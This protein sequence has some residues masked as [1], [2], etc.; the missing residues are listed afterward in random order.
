MLSDPLQAPVTSLSLREQIYARLRAAMMQGRYEPEMTLKISELAETFGTSVVP[1]REALQHLAAEGAIELLP[2]RSARIPHMTRRQFTELMG[3]RVLLESQAAREAAANIT[4]SEIEALE[5]ANRG[6][7]DAVTAQNMP[8]ILIA[9]QAFHFGLYQAS[10]SATLVQL[11]GTLW[12]RAGPM[13]QAAFRDVV[14]GLRMHSCGSDFHV[15]IL[16][17]LRARD[18][19]ASAQHIADDLEA[20]AQWY[21]NSYRFADQPLLTQPLASRARS[22]LPRQRV[23][24]TGK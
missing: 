22:R 8:A 2:N 21:L 16:E 19:T 5:A 9:N 24:V 13:L 15:H 1:V 3:V 4:A 6:I 18:E 14:G 7:R 20:A 11:I 17:A 23:L 10:R 12:L